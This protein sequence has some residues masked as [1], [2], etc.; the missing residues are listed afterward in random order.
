MRTMSVVSKILILIVAVA[1]AG[2]CSAQVRKLQGDNQRLI[3]E[4]NALNNKVSDLDSVVSSEQQ[5]SAQLEIDV[6]KLQADLDYYKG[7]GD[8][9]AG[10]YEDARRKGAIAVSEQLMRE[11]ANE[12]GAVY[13]PGGGIRLSSDVLFDSGKAE[14]KSSAQDSIKKVADALA[15]EKAKDLILRIDG[16]TDS[17]PIRYSGW[18]DNMQLSQAR[19]RSVWVDLKAGG[20][21][22]EKMFTAGFGEFKPIEDNGTAAGRSTNRRVELWLVPAPAAI[23]TGEAPAEAPRATIEELPEPSK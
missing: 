15:T 23:G 8:A 18:K 11:I 1:L 3:D 14:L 12:I 5:K 6:R 2:G 13:L 7:T 22:P 4:R 20:V 19:A 21:S 9:Y 17:Q 10:A 16:H